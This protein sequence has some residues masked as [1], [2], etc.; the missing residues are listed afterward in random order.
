MDNQIV[1][2]SQRERFKIH[3]NK[4][5]RGHITAGYPCGLGISP[6]GHWLMSG[7]SGGQIWFWDFKTKR[8]MK[9][10]KGH[11][12][13]VVGC[14]WHPIETSKVATCAWDGKIVYWD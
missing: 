13:A 3:L 2:Y 7:D 5:Y 12:S 9:T 11:S 4:V 8:I 6:D 1:T 14:E 10:L